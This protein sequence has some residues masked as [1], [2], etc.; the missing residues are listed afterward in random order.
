MAVALAVNQRNAGVTGIGWIA[1]TIMSVPKGDELAPTNQARPERGYIAI[2]DHDTTCR[3][4]DARLNKL[5]EYPLQSA[6][7]RMLAREW[8]LDYMRDLHAAYNAFE[9][10]GK[11]RT[12][13][14]VMK[15]RDKAEARIVRCP[16]CTVVSLQKFRTFHDGLQTEIEMEFRRVCAS[17]PRNLVRVRV[18]LNGAPRLDCS[19][20][21]IHA[22]RGGACSGRN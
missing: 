8:W 3:E 17:C 14:A 10:E 21:Y 9:T 11:V 1:T 4:L 6:P 5:P 16:L 20:V 12:L 19:A 13:Q 18:L 7:S 22:G 2:Q 15:A